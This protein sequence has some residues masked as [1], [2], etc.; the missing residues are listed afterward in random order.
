MLP[1]SLTSAILLLLLHTFNPESLCRRP[2]L[3]ELVGGRE[4]ILE[5]GVRS[6]KI[7]T[8]TVERIV[9]YSYVSAAAATTAGCCCN[10]TLQEHVTINCRVINIQITHANA[11]NE[12]SR[13]EWIA[14]YLY[15]S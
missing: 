12:H 6:S 15:S 8:Q 2:C 10:K 9:V 14:S 4:D 1:L 5:A 7:Y 13:A 11:Q 3:D